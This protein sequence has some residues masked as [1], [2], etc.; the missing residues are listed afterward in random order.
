MRHRVST[1]ATIGDSD[2]RRGAMVT[3]ADP[4]DERDTDG[5]MGSE[6]VREQVDVLIIRN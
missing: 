2:L 4:N 6:F 3:T 1:F 5:T